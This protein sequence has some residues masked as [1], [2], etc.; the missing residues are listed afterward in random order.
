[1][2]RLVIDTDVMV[3]AFESPSGAS[4]QLMLDILDSKA[5]LLLSVSLMLEYEAVLT[6]S[7]TLA[8]SGLS[9]AEVLE[10]LDDLSGR[11]VPVA[12]DYRWRPAARDADDDLVVETA[13]NGGADVIVTFNVGDMSDGAGQFGIAV[14]RPGTVLKRIRT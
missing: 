6:R 8:R 13:I 11:C 4:R 14:E 12:F 2:L 3:S 9:V 7:A 10:A 5:S 1:M